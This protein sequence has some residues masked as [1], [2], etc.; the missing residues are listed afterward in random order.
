[1]CAEHSRA[2]SGFTLAEAL[3]TL[4][5]IAILAGV[6]V[7]SF[8]DTVRAARL[9]TQIGEFTLALQQARSEAVKRGGRVTVCKSADGRACGDGRVNWEDG[10]I[11]F[12]DADRDQQLDAGET[13]LRQHA[14]LLP[15]Y[16][17]RGNANVAGALSFEATGITANAGSLVLCQRAQPRHARALVVNLAGRIRAAPD[18]DHDGAPELRSCRGNAE[19][20][21]TACTPPFIPGC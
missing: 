16:T 2:I 18:A 4:A 9:R 10:W 6:A 12:A 5:V 3:V 1:M 13:L 21:L 17:L 19:L 11:V 15:G 20:D 8:V 7:P 14:A